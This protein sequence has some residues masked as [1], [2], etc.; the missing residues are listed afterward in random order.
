MK[1][2]R[3]RT[4]KIFNTAVQQEGSDNTSIF[5]TLWFLLQNSLPNLPALDVAKS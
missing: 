2:L 3:Y 5:S 4:W 1:K